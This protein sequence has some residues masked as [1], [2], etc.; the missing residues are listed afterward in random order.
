MVDKNQK[1]VNYFLFI[2]SASLCTY[3]H[4]FSLLFCVLVALTGVFIV[5]LSNRRNYWLSLVAI[6]ILYLP[7]FSILHYQLFVSKGL[8]WLAE[9]S[10]TF[11]T[12]HLKYILQYSYVSYLL[13]FSL[14]IF[15]F[16]NINFNNIK[17]PYIIPMIWF[18]LPI[19][20]GVSYSIFISLSFKIQC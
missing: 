9:P 19:I 8:K 14:S 18:L 5:D 1:I 11:L 6:V 7:H 15:S 3:N 17:K 20:I 16:L 13:I 2:I 10:A 4:H 12:E